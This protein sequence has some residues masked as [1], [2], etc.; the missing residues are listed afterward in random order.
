MILT[1][2]WEVIKDVLSIVE[3]LGILVVIPIYNKIIKIQKQNKKDRKT[4]D[5]LPQTLQE[6]NNSITQVNKEVGEIKQVVTSHKKD[7]NEFEIQNLKFMIN[8]AFFTYGRLEDIPND[9]L[10]NACECCDIYVI[11]RGKN[12]EIRPRCTHLW[13]ELERRATNGER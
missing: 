3:L 4:L 8:D 5:D 7:Y 6:V 12:H 13:K 1:N 10:T 9:V 2:S 11:D